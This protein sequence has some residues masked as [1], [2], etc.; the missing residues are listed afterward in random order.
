MNLNTSINAFIGKIF[1]WYFS[2]RALPYWCV[3]LCD[4]LI[5]F[6]SLLVAHVLNVGFANVASNWPQLLISICVYLIFFIF[7]FRCFRTYSGVV[8]YSSFIDLFRLF[9]ALKPR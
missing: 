3:L 7:A 6:F 4:S 5:V 8:R 1:H 9:A 2:R